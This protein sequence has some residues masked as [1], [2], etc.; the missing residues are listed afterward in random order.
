MPLKINCD[1]CGKEILRCQSQI[2]RHNFCSRKCMA[3]FSSKSKNPNG[4]SALK[5]Y[6]LMSRNMT[7]LN[8][9]LNPTRMTNETREKLRNARLNCGDG[10]TYSK[11]YGVH[12]HRVVAE[13]T[14][15]RKLLPEEVVHHIDGNKRNNDESNLLVLSS[16]SEHA[17]LHMRDRAF[18][19]GGD[20]K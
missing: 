16:Q 9:K 1:W 8:K 20:A 3:Y 19:E 11:Y 15:G 7:Q 5:N 6:E 12:E 18:W 17:K 4:Y 10:V 14:I 2:K 13:K